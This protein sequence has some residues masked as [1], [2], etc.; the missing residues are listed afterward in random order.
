M[1]IAG[2]DLKSDGCTNYLTVVIM[3]Q[4][5]SNHHVLYVKFTHTIW[6]L[7]L[8]KAGKNQLIK[9]LLRISACTYIKICLIPFIDY[10][11]FNEHSLYH[12]FYR[13]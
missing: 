6:Q 4:Y 2:R 1:K 10:S 11:I 12:C 5:I 3:L 8:T 9:Y 13:F 7:Y